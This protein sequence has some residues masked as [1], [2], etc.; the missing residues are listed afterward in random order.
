MC[1]M[2]WPRAVLFRTL[3]QISLSVVQDTSWKL[4]YCLAGPCHKVHCQLQ[5]HTLSVGTPTIEIVPDSITRNRVWPETRIDR[6]EE[7]REVA[8]PAKFANNQLLQASDNVFST[9]MER[10]IRDPGQVLRLVSNPSVTSGSEP[11]L[12]PRYYR[13]GIDVDDPG[14][15][16]PIP[17]LV[18]QTPVFPSIIP[19][20]EHCGSARKCEFQLLPTIL[21]TLKSTI[22]VIS[23]RSI[24]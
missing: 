4:T 6:H 24:S 19:P 15:H 17:L 13:T 8:I 20:C 10:I 7:P 1:K 18:N 22:F 9:Y 23:R 21:D 14:V 2:R 16:G 5:N 3:R 12:L 11:H